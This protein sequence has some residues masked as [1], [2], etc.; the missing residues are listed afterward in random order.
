LS[1]DNLHAIIS[2][3][4]N[5]HAWKPRDHRNE[6][7]IIFLREQTENKLLDLLWV[8]SIY[9]KTL[10]C[11]MVENTNSTIL[12]VQGSFSLTYMVG[13][14]PPNL[15]SR[16]TRA[17]AAAASFCERLSREEP[18][19][20]GTREQNHFRITTQPQVRVFPSRDSARTV[21]ATAQNIFLATWQGKLDKDLDHQ[22]AW[23]GMISLFPYCFT[24][25]RLYMFHIFICDVLYV[26]I[27]L[28]YLF[29]LI[30]IW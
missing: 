18:L 25:C 9:W 30:I 16:A 14:I 12:E 22:S 15:R 23:E 1:F 17:R 26:A 6:Y 27:I 24:F 20:L 5:A 10:W 21:Y 29:C 28:S 19:S 4:S 8:W 2:L 13:I 3:I 11:V 7:F